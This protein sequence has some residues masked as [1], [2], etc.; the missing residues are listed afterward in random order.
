MNLMTFS[1][2]EQNSKMMQ[3]IEGDCLRTKVG[4]LLHMTKVNCSMDNVEK[5]VLV[6][7]I[8]NETLFGRRYERIAFLVRLLIHISIVKALMHFWDPGFK[9]FT[10]RDVNMTPTIEEYALILNFIN[11]RHKVYFRQRI[12]DTTV[13][14][15]K[16][17]HLGQVDQ[18]R[19]TNRGF[20]WKLIETKLKEIKDKG[21]LRE[22][23]YQTVAFA[24]FGFVWF[25]LE[26]VSII[27]VEATN[28]F[29]EYERT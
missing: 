26:V 27:S 2:Y 23:R 21:K 22:E 3:L 12:K 16:L 8:V 25:P 15:A 10:F 1:E 9:C 29:V 17:L 18:Y 24:I 14:V 5:L 19:T 4:E 11:E 28:A 7:S 6:L 20:N 13:D